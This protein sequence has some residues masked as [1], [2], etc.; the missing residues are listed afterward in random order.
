MICLIVFLAVLLLAV[1]VSCMPYNVP[2]Q[3]LVGGK[4]TLV[5]LDDLESIQSYSIFFSDLTKRGH[6]L[7]FFQAESSDLKLK[8]YGETLYDNLVFFAPLTDRFSLISFEDITE[9]SNEG[10]N[11]LIAVNKETS[12]AV[13]D[14][15]ETFGFSLDKKGS[16]VIDHFN[17]ENSVD[18]SLQHVN[19]VTKNSIRSPS[20][21]GDYARDTKSSPV[22]FHGVGHSID[23][24][25]VLSVSVLRGSETAYSASPNKPIGDLPESAGQ[26]SL[27]VSAVQARN[28][29]RVVLSGSL[30]LFSNEFFRAHLSSHGNQQSGNEL[31]CRELSRWALG[32]S[33][34]LRFRDISHRKSDGT[35]PDV[36]LHEKER[37]DLPQSLFPDPE[38]T[39]NSLVYRIKDEIVYSMVVE[40]LENGNWIPFSTNDMQMEFVM[41]DPYIRK[42]MVADNKGKFV[43]SF[44]APDSYGVFKF[45]VLYRRPGYSVLHAETQVSIRPFKHDE[46]ERFIFSATPYYSSAISAAVA[47]LLFSIMF[48][49]SGDDK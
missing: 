44:V 33:G 39:R 12:D 5:I 8:M 11:I 3:G 14:F 19:I 29:A 25:S 24:K 15:V 4:R 35:P 7:S 34:V 45:R 43:A 1:Q 48:L 47:L 37:P 42:T 21:L 31:F 40:E 28:N 49:F 22:L 16:E 9:F 27:L 10:G 20:I 6:V 18:V 32:E 23:A 38:I 17:S 46:Y 26:D 2:L 30:D 36:I 41:M 13:R